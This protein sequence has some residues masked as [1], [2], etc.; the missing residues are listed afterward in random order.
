MLNLL[1]VIFAVNL[2]SEGDFVVFALSAMVTVAT[3]RKINTKSI[4]EVEEGLSKCYKH[5]Q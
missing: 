4:K 3:K 2:A 1:P 5:Y